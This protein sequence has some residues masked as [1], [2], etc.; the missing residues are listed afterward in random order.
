NY[1]CC[2]PEQA[3]DNLAI[4]N[5]EVAKLE[6]G[7]VTLAELE[8]AKNKVCS[9]TVLRSERPSSRLFSVGNGWIQR[10]QYLSVAETVAA[11]KS[12]TL[13][14]VHNVL[15]K[16]PLSQCNTLAIGPLAEL[17]QNA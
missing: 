12:V 13:D 8:Q 4:L 11:Y 6:S 14:D 3:A 5:E 9:S 10:G 15:A 7:G 17:T 1:L 2:S 16:Y